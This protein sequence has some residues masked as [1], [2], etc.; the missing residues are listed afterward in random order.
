MN[1]PA[2]I[3]NTRERL[4]EQMPVTEKWAYMDHAAVSPLPKPTSVAMAKWLQQASE[5]GDTLWL[6]WSAQVQSTRTEAARMIGASEEEIALVTSTTAGINFVAEGLDWQAGD[7]VV[8]LDD[9]F[10]SNLYP[11]MHLQ[12]QGVETRLVPT[13]NGLVDYER[14]AERCDDR[15][16]L[17]TVSW[18][19]YK[20]G[21][22]RDIDV[23]SQIA[24]DKNALFLV[25]AIQGIGAFP[26]DVRQT[27]I[28]FLAADGH[29]WQLGPEG[30]GFAYIRRDCLPLLRATGVGWNS[31]VQG[32]DFANIN[33]NL[34]TTAARYEGGSQNMAGLI[35][36]GQSLN[37]LNNLGVENVSASILDITDNACEQLASCGAELHTPRCG[38]NRS[39]IVTFSLPDVDARAFRKH[40]LNSGVALACRSGRLRISL[41][42]YNHDGDIGR[43]REAIRSFGTN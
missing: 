12:D 42:G 40:C 14:L 7:N 21:A 43:L 5:E 29:K 26:L 19:G 13:D 1:D 11:W 15:T 39:G 17:I 37:L 16:R 35:G 27:Q 22:R 6:D 23:I 38:D 28:D 20:N 18:V 41:H 36:L 33:L 3:A 31:V 8:T 10:P 2:T 24:R 30:A 34:K 25:D 32:S 9:E 4:R